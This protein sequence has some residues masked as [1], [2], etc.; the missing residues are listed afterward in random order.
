MFVKQEQ[1]NKD[2]GKKLLNYLI[3]ELHINQI[4]NI[5]LLTDKGILAEKFYKNNG[6]EEIERI[7]FLNKNIKQ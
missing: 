5:I 3:K 2:I 7:I 6:F 1:Q 4:N